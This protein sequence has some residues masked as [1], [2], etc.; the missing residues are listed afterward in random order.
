MLLDQLDHD[1]LSLI[2]ILSDVYTILS[3]SRVNKRFHALGRAKHLWISVVRDLYARRLIDAPVDEVLEQCATQTLID[4]VRRIV[5]GPY[6]WSP[7]SPI[8][9][10]IRRQMSIMLPSP[11]TRFEFLPG[12]RYLVLYLMKD[13]DVEV[14]CLEISSERR[15]WSWARA[16]HQVRYAGFDLDGSGPQGVAYLV[17]SD[18]AEP[19]DQLLILRIN[20]EPGESMELLNLSDPPFSIDW[21]SRPQISGDFLVC[22]VNGPSPGDEYIVVVNWQSAQFVIMDFNWAQFR[23]VHD[24]LIIIHPSSKDPPSVTNHLRIYSIAALVPF[25]HPLHDFNSSSIDD[26]FRTKPTEVPCLASATI[27]A[28]APNHHVHLSVAESPLHDGRTHQI[29]VSLIDLAPP[30]PLSR[31]K[32]L[33]NRMTRRGQ[34]RSE[35]VTTLFRY[36]LV[37]DDSDGPGLQLKSTL[38]HTFPCVATYSASYGLWASPWAAS[39]IV[40]RQLDE[41][42]IRQARAL[43]VVEG[44]PQ[45]QVELSPSGAVVVLYETRIVVTY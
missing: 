1:V 21:I 31:F 44:E 8:A 42:G 19:H 13:S 12:G 20:F 41:V 40:V 27:C 16:G 36:R 37:L 24:H 15:V 10:T 17:F 23:L 32:K 9:P 4:R 14:E 43:P 26:S 34:P 6:T 38:R 5:L 3:L 39:T 11:R 30:P 35:W 18:N 29:I 45:Y 2:F 25:W 7:K 22:L 28:A 33:R